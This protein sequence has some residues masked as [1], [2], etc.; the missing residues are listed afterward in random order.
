LTVEVSDELDV[1][2]TGPAEPVYAGE[3]SPELV[4]AL[5]EL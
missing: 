3:L 1:R 2:L 4:A 5:G